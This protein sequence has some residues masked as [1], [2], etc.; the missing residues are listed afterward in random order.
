MYLETFN[1]LGCDLPLMPKGM[2]ISF[3]D[4]EKLLK[5]GLAAIGS[6]PG[7][8]RGKLVNLPKYPIFVSRMVKSECTFESD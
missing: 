8:V 7:D 3:E 6:V 5:E 2:A 1:S 4:R